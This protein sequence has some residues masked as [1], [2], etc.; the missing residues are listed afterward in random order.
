[1]INLI[2]IKLRKDLFEEISRERARQ[3]LKHPYPEGFPK[4]LRMEILVEEIGEVSKAKIEG[5]QAQLRDELIQVAATALR[6][7]ECLDHEKVIK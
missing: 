2:D 7:I 5:D 1:M 4:D 3:D 6:W